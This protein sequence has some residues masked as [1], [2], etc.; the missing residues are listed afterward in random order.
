MNIRGFDVV[1][2][3]VHELTYQVGCVLSDAH[4]YIISFP[5]SRPWS[6]TS[7]KSR[8]TFTRNSS[9]HNVPRYCCYSQLPGND[10]ERSYDIT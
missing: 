7:Y 4:T 8:K 9:L 3:L 1:S 2:P 5:H 10:R 6:T